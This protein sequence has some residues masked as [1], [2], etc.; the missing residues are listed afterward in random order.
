MNLGFAG[1]VR[2]GDID[3]AGVP[4]QS[5]LDD[6]GDFANFF[7]IRPAELQVNGLA[8]GEQIVLDQDLDGSRNPADLV[9]PAVRDRLGADCSE[10]GGQQFEVDF[11][12][13]VAQPACGTAHGAGLEFPKGMLAD[14][15]EDVH[16]RVSPCLLG[17]FGA[18][19]L[20]GALDPLHARPG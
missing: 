3:H 13:K 12:E 5:G 8:R 6:L 19:L 9:A 16:D 17:E 11:S 18:H 15:S 4:C 10:L 20:D 14:G 7:E 2:I 1:P